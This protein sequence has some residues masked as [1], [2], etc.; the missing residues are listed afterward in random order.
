VSAAKTGTVWGLL[1][2]RG[3]EKIMGTGFVFL[4]ENDPVPGFFAAMRNTSQ[5]LDGRNLSS[6]IP[7]RNEIT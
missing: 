4:A 1:K 6:I 7:L 2:K 3:G 5:L